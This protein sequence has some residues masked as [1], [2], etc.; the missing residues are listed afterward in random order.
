MSLV[1]ERVSADQIRQ[2]PFPQGVARR[3]L[4]VW[5]PS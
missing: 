5:Q 2:E 1:T 4:L 3:L